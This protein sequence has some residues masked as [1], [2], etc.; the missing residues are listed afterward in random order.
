M[1]HRK[2]GRGKTWVMRIIT[3]GEGRKE[4]EGV[5]YGI[6]TSLV[7]RLLSALL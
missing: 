2:R 1:R 3:R 7:S 6:L 4:G 5:A